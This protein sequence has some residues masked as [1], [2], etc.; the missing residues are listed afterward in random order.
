M[1]TSIGSQVQK[2]L[3]IVVVCG[4]LMAPVVILITLP[5]LVSLF[6]DRGAEPKSAK[7]PADSPDFVPTGA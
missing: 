7:P 5:V 6:G 1:S 3:A 4:M 2:P